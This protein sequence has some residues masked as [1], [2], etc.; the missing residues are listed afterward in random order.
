MRIDVQTSRL[1]TANGSIATLSGS[2]PNLD[3]DVALAKGVKAV[4][5]TV[6]T[7]AAETKVT[8]LNTEGGTFCVTV[9]AADK[10][11]TVK[12]CDPLEAPV[13]IRYRDL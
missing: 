5:L 3:L 12:V 9:H 11:P 7:D 2:L 6:F 4:Y 1:A 8:S 13:V 10:R